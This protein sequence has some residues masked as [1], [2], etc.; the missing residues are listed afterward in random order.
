V[1]FHRLP[2]LWR[3]NQ[4]PAGETLRPIK[5]QAELS[6]PGAGFAGYTALLEG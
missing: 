4:P 1:T 2:L 6:H 5:A 3:E